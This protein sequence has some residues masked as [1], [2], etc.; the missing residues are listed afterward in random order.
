M[1]ATTPHDDELLPPRE[2]GRLVGVTLKTLSNWR[3]RRPLRLPFVRI[4]ARA[5][6]YRRGD[7]LAF[8]ADRRVEATPTHLHPT[9]PA[10][11]AGRP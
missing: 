9:P 11:Q 4:S 5:V 1:L 3:W 7:V 8:L 10:T 6:R 2:V